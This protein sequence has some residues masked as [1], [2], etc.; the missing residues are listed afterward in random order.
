MFS[1]SLCIKYQ[2]ICLLEDAYGRLEALERVD[3]TRGFDVPQLHA[4]LLTGEQ[5]LVQVGDRMEHARELEC[6]RIK[7]QVQI[8]LY[9]IT[10]F[11]F[12]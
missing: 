12:V 10:I 9:T 4:A 7:A 3:E 11:D 8:D 2:D 6:A 5:N 1:S